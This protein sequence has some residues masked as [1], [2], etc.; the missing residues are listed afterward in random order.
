MTSIEILET[1]GLKIP[2]L[3]LSGSARDC[4]RQ[5]GS[6][7][8]R[9]IHGTLDAYLESFRAMHGLEREKVYELARAFVPCIESYAPELVEEMQG[10]ADGADLPL[11]AIVTLNARSEL[12]HGLK[13]RASA[14]GCTSFAVLG[15]A[16]RDGRLLV[17]QNW[18]WNP[19]MRASTV[20]LD[21]ERAGAPRLITLAETGLLGKIGVNEAGVA[22]VINFLLSDQRRPG[23]PVHVIRRRVLEAETLPEALRAVVQ[24]ERALAANYLLAH[25]DSGAVAVEAWPE[26]FAVVH[27]V[28]GVLTHANHFQQLA[29]GRRDL[30]KGIFPDSLLRDHRLRE[31]FMAAHGTID[32]A[33]CQ[34]ALADHAGY[35]ESVCRHHNP[36]LPASA[37]I[38]TLGGVV[39]DPAAGTLSFCSGNPCESSF[40]TV[41]LDGA[42]RAAQRTAP[43]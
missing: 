12:V 42:P 14:D 7:L 18:D 27:P 43:A 41:A 28:D 8:A 20:I 15:P 35:P 13:A 33:C 21:I 37:R 1:G 32:A 2:R 10:I 39:I 16:T 3:R 29:P 34:R 36:I 38:Q 4:G 9:S 19:A 6:A 5:Y 11:D 30:G 40:V 22:S 26:D 17:G 24:A 23:V 25:P 31:V